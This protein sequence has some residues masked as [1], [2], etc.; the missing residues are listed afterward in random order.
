MLRYSFFCFLSMTIGFFVQY[1]STQAQTLPQKVA[2]VGFL[3]KMTGRFHNHTLPIK[4]EILLGTLVI[5][6]EACYRSAPGD[7]NES[8]A[9]FDI[10]DNLIKGSDNNV[11]RGWMFSSTP[12]LSSL[13]HSSFDVWLVGCPKSETN[14]SSGSS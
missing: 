6:I 10:H 1:Q 11:F 5:R 3:D 13:E 7:R 14:D 4:K 12:S 8:A 9:F 2:I